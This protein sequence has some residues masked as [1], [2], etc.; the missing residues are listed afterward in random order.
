MMRS[1]LFF[2]LVAAALNAATPAFPQERSGSAPCRQGA[3]ALIA[4]LDS[5]DDTS[6]DYRA[7]YSGVVQSCGPAPRPAKVMADRNIC[8]DLALK[9]LDAIEDGRLQSQDFA[10]ARNS[11][12]ANCTPR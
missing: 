7:A 2:G 10:L 3:L 4:M 12:A 9:M 11:F 5:G 8:R 6:G 1:L